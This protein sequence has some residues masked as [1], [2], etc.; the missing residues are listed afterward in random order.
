SG[1][2]PWR[3]IRLA[4]L[5]PRAQVRYFYLSTL[6]RAADQGIARRPAQT[7][8]EFVEDLERTW[9]ESELDVQSLTEAFIS[10]RYDAAEISSDEARQVKS[11][12]ERI[13]RALRGKGKREEGAS[14]ELH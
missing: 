7:P 12:W 1:R 11:V 3:F 4:G 8:R 10:A 14:N 5:P 13:K 2:A 6:R 9:P